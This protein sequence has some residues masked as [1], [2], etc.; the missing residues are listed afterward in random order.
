MSLISEMSSPTYL[1]SCFLRPQ[2]HAQ[3]EAQAQALASQANAAQAVQSLHHSGSM[4]DLQVLKRRCR[5]LVVPGDAGL[6]AV[7][8]AGCSMHKCI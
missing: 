5:S 1:T 8:N 7:M 6:R 2:A 4:Q 3:A